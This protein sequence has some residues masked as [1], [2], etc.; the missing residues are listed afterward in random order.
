MPQRLSDIAAAPRRLGVVDPTR[1]AKPIRFGKQLA[2]IASRSAKEVLYGIGGGKIASYFVAHKLNKRMKEQGI[3]P[4][5][6]SETQ[7]RVKQ[8]LMGKYEE[9]IPEAQI[10]PA[11]TVG[12]KAVDVAAGITG[13]VTK[14]AVLKKAF[15]NIGGAALWEMENLSSGGKPGVGAA[16]YGIFNLPG[17]VI[18]GT[19]IAAKGGRL[20]SESALLGGVSAAHQKIETGEI[21]AKEVLISAGIPVGLKALGGAKGV[22]KRALKSKNPAAIKATNEVIIKQ[23][24]DLAPKPITTDATTQKLLEQTAVAKRL[25]RTEVKEAIAKLRRTQAARGTAVEVKALKERLPAREAL[26]RAEAAQKGKARVPE[27]TPPNLT[28]SEW[29]ELYSRIYKHFPADDVT[30]RFQRQGSKT[31]LD[32]LRTGRVPTNY[33][34]GFLDILLGREATLKLHENIHKHRT[35]GLWDVPI[36]TRDMLKSMFGWDPQAWRQLLGIVSRHPK[37]YSKAAAANIRGYVSRTEAN[38]ITRAIEQSPNF[39]IGK[40][41]MGVN[42]LGTTPWTSIKAGNKLQQY[43]V[44]TDFLLSRKNKVLRAWGRGLAA[45]ERGANAGINTGLNGLVGQGVRDLERLQAKRLRLGK[46]P[47]TETQVNRWLDQRGKDINALTKR[48]VAKNPKAR[49]IQRA[50]QWILFSSAHTVSRPIAVARSFKNIFTGKGL[51]GRTYAAQVTAANIAKLSLLSY[52][53]ANVGHKWRSENSTEEPRIDSSNNPLNSL[54]GKVRIGNDVIDLSGGDN[55]TYRLLARLGVS[56]YLYGQEML[57]GERRTTVA[58]WRVKGPGEELKQYL[59]SRETV[60]LGLAKTLATGKDWVGND[61]GRTEAILKQFPLEFLVSV[62][63]AG[64][65]DGMWEAISQGDISEASADFIKNLPIGVAGLTGMG[66]L[67]YK[68]PAAQTRAKFKDIIAKSKYQKSWDDLNQK[69]QRT[70]TRTY[71][72]QLQKL[73]ERVEVERVEKPFDPTRLIE[74]E[75]KA[76]KRITKMLSKTNRP[77]TSGIPLGVSRRPRNFYLNDRRYQKYQELV[78]KYL[79]QQLSKLKVEGKSDRV[80]KLRAEAAF[81]IAKNKAY[82]DVRKMK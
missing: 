72:K 80:R 12:E 13:F 18:K 27:I 75:R 11:E 76:G 3:K 25:R 52:I 48:V 82:R 62:V 9:R 78:A 41:K 61:I 16:T 58:G 1:E 34:F 21:D 68:V 69:E 70:L 10:K 28:N 46:K 44:W 29:E 30:L 2:N 42:Y 15:P 63:E 53:I 51:A 56:A 79:N 43:G 64:N 47:L 33:D 19:S 36:L 24:P 38:R 8:A 55:S 81:R 37:I 40:E 77:K 32:K 6:L 66:T 50:S 39:K 5:S 60:L 23:E 54:W 4:P 65:A 57:T 7:K 14:L 20:V 74:E 26:G 17:K 22:L 49:E 31:A 71:R 67:T 45:A 35:Y 59:T 73:D